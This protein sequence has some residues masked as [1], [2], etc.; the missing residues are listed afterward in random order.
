MWERLAFSASVFQILDTTDTSSNALV[1]SSFL[2]LVVRPGAPSSYLLLVV[3]SSN[4]LVT[5]ISIIFCIHTDV[6]TIFALS[7][8]HL[9]ACRLRSPES[10][11]QG[12]WFQRTKKHLFVGLTS[13][14][15]TLHHSLQDSPVTSV[16]AALVSSPEIYIQ[17][18]AVLLRLVEKRSWPVFDPAAFHKMQIP[19]GHLRQS[20]RAKI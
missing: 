15:S 1:T 17:G 11:L 14:E 13:D 5:S 20:C 6:C 9:F 2:L 7:D 10:R 19:N 12:V 18:P 8:F 16:T 4:A 3:S